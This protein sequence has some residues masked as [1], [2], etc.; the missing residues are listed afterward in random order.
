MIALNRCRAYLILQ[1]SCLILRVC[2]LENQAA[3][4]KR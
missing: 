1:T 3:L 4:R 2:L